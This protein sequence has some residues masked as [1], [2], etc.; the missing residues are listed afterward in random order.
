VIGV[1]NPELKL[2]PYLTADVKFEVDDR[3]D[4]LLIPNAALRYKPAPEL[5][6]G[7]DPAENDENVE[8][9]PAPKPGRRDKEGAATKGRL[10][11]ATDNG[12]LKPVEVQIG[13]SDGV[14]TEITGGD[15]KEGDEF[16]S[17]EEKP[18]ATAANGDVNPFAP[19]RFG[20]R[21]PR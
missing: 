21:R 20:R 16:V 17:G 8:G 10:W 18:G 11:L 1:D 7:Y 19:L 4:V 13:I 14:V 3:Q 2:L 9:A 15:V 5:I 6:V 12:K